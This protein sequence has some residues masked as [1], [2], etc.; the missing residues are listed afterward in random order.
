MAFDLIGKL[1][2]I[3][4]MTGP[5]K[6]ATSAVQNLGNTAS[7]GNS[8][9]S[10]LVGTLGKI[11]SAI[12]IVKLASDTVNE[13]IKFDD[14][15]TGIGAISAEAKTRRKDIEALSN[16][17]G[18]DTVYS[19]VEAADA[20]GELVRAGRTV[21][22]VIGGDLA[23]A[24]NIAAA[25]GMSLSEASIIMSDNMNAFGKSGIT[26]EQ[27]ANILAGTSAAASTDVAGL[28]MGLKNVGAVAATVGMSMEDTATALGLLSNA[29][30]K[31]ADAG[32]SLKSMLLNLQPGTKKQTQLM[33]KLGLMTKKGA[34]LFYDEK[35][36]MKSL[37]DISGLLND[38]MKDMTSQQRL[39]AMETLFGTDA[40]RAA[41]VLFDAGADGVNDFNK[42]MLGVTAAD[43]ANEKLSST[44]GKIEQMNGSLD[45]LKQTI[46][47]QALPYVNM[48]ADAATTAAN[49][50]VTWIESTEGQAF[51]ADVKAGIDTFLDTMKALWGWMQETFGPL[52]DSIKQDITDLATAISTWV[53]TDQAKACFDGIKTAVE[54][55]VTAITNLRNFLTDKLV[56]GNPIIWGLVAGFIAFKV[57]TGAIAF[58]E[59]IGG[60]SGAA[61]AAW[62]FTAAL[63]ANPATWIALAVMALVAVGILLWKNWDQVSAWLIAL[64]A[65]I[66][67]KATE[68]WNGIASFFTGI[69][70]SISSAATSA[71]QG[72]SSTVT[73]LWQ[74]VSNF[75]GGITLADVGMA[76]VNTLLSGFTGGWSGLLSSLAGLW[77]QVA[78]YFGGCSLSTIGSN[79]ITGLWNGM[80]SVWD[81][82]TKWFNDLVASIP[83]WVRDALGIHSPSR[84]MME[85]GEYTMKGFAIGMDN[86][87][88]GVETSA[89]RIAEVPALAVS[90]H[91]ADTERATAAI[92]TTGTAPSPA[93]RQVHLNVEKIELHGVAGDLRAAATEL[94]GYFAE[95]LDTD[96]E[97]VAEGE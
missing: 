8:N 17:L 44:A 38:K 7:T 16:Q 59:L 71:W 75:F 27:A 47:T 29:G 41:S 66:S 92:N 93:P 30:I 53:Q 89:V 40:I 56:E 1:Q 6:S 18:K 28:A 76:I 64:W 74:G 46:G 84:V 82:V 95:I 88:E 77:N 87:R 21:D 97:L 39:K 10:G 35:G 33:K 19:S 55:A 32:T 62:G 31:G 94:M 65:T 12:G 22:Q 73:G 52:V 37:S 57:A 23:A 49:N 13:A 51:F 2:L 83:Q 4:Q 45:L 36:N 58:M 54:G 50:M 42:A 85:L 70:S 48:F 3:D 25:D 60:F 43:M 79:I 14:A 5:L 80:K 9:L 15:I 72:F 63:L 34:N 68:I 91:A 24:L 20:F 67:A 69:W 11:A 96:G 86:Q 26:A 81:G 61:A 90:T 78:S